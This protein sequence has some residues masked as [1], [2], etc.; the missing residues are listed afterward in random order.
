MGV[1]ARS[2]VINSA[3]LHW[4]LECMHTQPMNSMQSLEWFL[5]VAVHTMHIL[6]DTILNWIR[7]CF[8]LAHFACPFPVFDTVLTWLTL[9]SMRVSLCVCA[10]CIC[11]QKSACI[12]HQTTLLR[13][14][15]Y[16][17]YLRIIITDNNNRLELF[18]LPFWVFEQSTPP[19]RP[20]PSPLPGRR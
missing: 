7:L 16:A 3:R 12:V 14:C 17:N 10:M 1:C 18:H 13:V 19:P 11:V 20:L 2:R 6:K 15:I 4:I 9:A 5:Y 8:S